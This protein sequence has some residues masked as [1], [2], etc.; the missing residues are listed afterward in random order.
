MTAHFFGELSDSDSTS[1]DD[2]SAPDS[3]SELES[4]AEENFDLVEEEAAAQPQPLAASGPG[5]RKK[6][7]SNIRLSTLETVSERVHQGCQCRE[8]NCFLKIDLDTLHSVMNCCEELTGSELQIFIAGK[9]D[10]LARRDELAHHGLA[11]QRAV[12]RARVTYHYEVSGV[13]VC[14]EVFMYAHC[15]SA[16]KLSSIHDHLNAGII[17]PPHHRSAGTLPWNAASIDEVQEILQFI[18][19]YASINGLPQPAAPRGHNKPAP[20]YLPCA[21]TKKLVHALYVK[22]GGKVAY[23]TFVKLWNMHCKTIVIMSPKEDVCCKCADWQSAIARARTEEDRLKFTDTLRVH[24]MEANSARDEYRHAIARAK[25]AKNDQLPNQPPEYEHLTFDFAQQAT[26]PHHAREVG[27]LYFKVPRR[28]QLFGIAAESFPKQVNYVFDEHQ[29][30]GKDGSKAHG[31]N[32]VI[33]M[34]HF[35]LQ[36][37]RT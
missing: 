24:I 14:K 23:T 7:P 10:V 18:N 9:L 33:S 37:H 29:S 26:I 28:I 22:A 34:L 19:H 17:A 21:T 15:V 35:P 16:H 11:A 3:T 36:N 32:S 20:T 13:R 30:I 4:D 31:P 12:S 6:Q 8:G 1:S 2:P 5:K 25:Q 27:A